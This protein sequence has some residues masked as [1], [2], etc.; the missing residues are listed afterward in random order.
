MTIT[1]YKF[2]YNRLLPA[3]FRLQDHTAW[4]IWVPILGD[5]VRIKKRA[6]NY[7][8][9]Q[10]GNNVLVYSIGAG[11]ELDFIMDKI[12]REGSVIGIDFSEGMLKIAREK[13]ER[14]NW[15]NVKLVLADVRE[16]NP[17][18]EAGHKFNA[19]LSNFG[20]LDETVLYNLISAIKIGGG[21][22]ISGPQPLRGAKKIFY[23]VTFVPEMIFGLTWK[24]LHKF[25]MYIGILKN[26]LENIKIDDNTFAKYFVAV[27]G[28]K[29]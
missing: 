24:T 20:Y 18:N 28:T 13:V 17:V 14:N 15:T 2:L 9:L 25:P 29:K 26:E 8:K 7:L 11:Y 22:A 19:A 4:F 1:L 5:V 12:G 16:Y 21:I 3:L 10:R 23:P 6:I 27:S